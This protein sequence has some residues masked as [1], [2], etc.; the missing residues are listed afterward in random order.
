MRL[1]PAGGDGGRPRAGGRARLRR[2]RRGDRARA[3]AS[4]LAAAGR[5]PRGRRGDGPHAGR[6]RLVAGGWARV[7]DERRAHRGALRGRGAAEGDRTA[8]RARRRADPRGRGSRGLHARDD[9]RRRDAPRRADPLAADPD[10]GVHRPA[11]RDPAAKRAAPRPL[12]GCGPRVPHRSRRPLT[13]RPAPGHLSPP[14]TPWAGDVRPLLAP[15]R[16]RVGGL[17]AARARPPLR[18]RARAGGHCAGR[19]RPGG[20]RP[21]DPHRRRARDRVA[22]AHGRRRGRRGLPSAGGEPMPAPTL[23]RSA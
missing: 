10:D 3:A 4:R 17:A 15:R 18:L 22:R 11:G 1:R 5:A 13:D 21:G 12:R 7:R 23:R 8:D 9:P 6:C 20:P 2:G 19:V 16:G 14:G